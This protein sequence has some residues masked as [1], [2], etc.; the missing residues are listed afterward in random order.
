MP[1][2]AGSARPGRWPQVPLLPAGMALLTIGAFAFRFSRLLETPEPTGTDGYYYL[3]QIE[4]LLTKGRLHVPDASWVLAFLA[5]CASLLGKKV[6]ALKFGAALLAAL[7]VPAAWLVGDSLES[8]PERRRRLAWVLGAWAAASPTLTHLA[9]DFPKNLGI[10][11]PLLLAFGLAVRTRSAWTLAGACACVLLAA[12]AHRIGAALVLLALAGLVV[13]HVCRR[14]KLRTKSWVLPAVMLGSLLL[15]AALTA[16]LPNLLHPADLERLERQLSF[17]PGWPPPFPYFALR[18]TH[19]VQMVELALPWG[20]G[21]VALIR[22]LRTPADRPLL[23]TLLLPLGACLFPWWRPDVLDMGYRLGL[24][25]PLLAAGLLAAMST[26]WRTRE[27]P[28]RSPSRVAAVALVLAGV[29]ALPLNTLG[30]DPSSAPPYALYRGLVTRIPRPL[31]EL[32]IAHQG[33]NFLYDHLTGREA[34]AWAPETE[35][36][37]TRVGGVVWGVEAGE[38]MELLTQRPEL[39]PPVP[40]GSSYSYAREDVWEALLS[41]ARSEGDEEL[42]A[43]LA[44]WRNPQNQRPASLSRNH[45]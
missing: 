2:S 20:V 38:W 1:A 27:T 44:D 11:A 25:A 8:T 7:C 10:A 22:F 32:L 40:L 4:D 24:M 39:P 33:V 43:R 15:F 5:G 30:F 34:M 16:F 21:L 13:G 23:S 37:R 14:S 9:G 42:L 19:P 45:R 29:L 41:K 31:P 12:T 35:L 28:T 3:V 36:D 17:R 18:P 6:F 26:S